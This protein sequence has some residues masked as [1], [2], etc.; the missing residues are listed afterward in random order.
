MMKDL[1][2]Y[3]LSIF[4]CFCYAGYNL[5]SKV[6]LDEGMSRYVLVVYAHA[7]GT[8]AT[9]VLAFLFER[10]HLLLFNTKIYVI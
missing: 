6:S 5:V 1:K 9:A 7:F 3:M 2:P 10:L 8:L 4:C